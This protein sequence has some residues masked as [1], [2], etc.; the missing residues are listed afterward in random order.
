MVKVSVIIPVYNVEQYLE[1]CIKSVQCQ[2]LKEI[3]IICID[4]G[5]TDHSAEILERYAELDDRI[6][7][8]SKE[9]TGYGHSVNLGI[10]SA[11]GE[12]ISI[13]ESDDYVELNMLEELYELAK[14]N[15]LD[16]VKADSTCFVDECGERKFTYR[17]VLPKRNQ[18]DYSK[19]FSRNDYNQTF[20]GYVYTWA[21]IYKREFLNQ[22]Y[23]RHNETPGASYQDNGFWFQTTM[24]ADRLMFINKA[25]YNLRRDNP[26][27]SFFSKT[28]VFCI[29]DEYDFIHQKIMESDLERKQELFSLCFQYRFANYAWTMNRIDPKFFPEF[30]QRMRSDFKK[31]LQEGEVDATLLSE[32]Q[33][34][35]M[36]QVIGSE[37]PV[38]Y[39]SPCCIELEAVGSLNKAKRIL[40]YGAGAYGRSAYA[41]LEKAG[42]T[43]KVAGFIV[44][45]KYEE[46]ELVYGLH[47]IPFAEYCV[48]EEDVII[49]AVS[50]KYK[51]QIWGTL[52]KAGINN[53]ID[54]D[55]IYH[56]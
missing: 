37:K 38:P 30:Y 36:Y 54:F 5:S 53:E 18:D 56:L 17:T 21:G 15:N 39:D 10:N 46:P 1:E 8:I 20:C 26:N 55:Q 9:N 16:V 35:Y 12:Y 25:Y 14:S 23:I 48:Q 47:V 2:S 6:R 33:W 44:T 45:E 11:R 19:I 49:V 40:I 41:L 13:V 4:D 22:Y 34:K 43:D 24:Y 27:S 29:S 50:G 28:K 7:V 52:R 3:E 42:Y 32:K 51:E 31:A